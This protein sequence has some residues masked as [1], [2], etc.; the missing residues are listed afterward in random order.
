MTDAPHAVAVS[1]ST[2]TLS[3]LGYL[4]LLA[5]SAKYPASTV[6]GLLLGSLSSPSQVTI[7]DAIPLLHHWTSLSM[8]LEAGLQLVSPPSPS[9]PPT[10]PSLSEMPAVGPALTC[11]GCCSQA[12]VYAKS[13]VWVIVGLYVANAGLEEVGVPVTLGPA[14]EA[15]R[16][17]CPQGCV[18]VVSSSPS[19]TTC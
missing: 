16:A 13:Q 14:V 5:H 19:F 11:S 18:L 15:L 9:N 12:E 3:P 17:N 6:A 10:H 1:S 8:A 4:K 2:Y 7:E